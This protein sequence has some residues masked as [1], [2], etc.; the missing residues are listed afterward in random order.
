MNKTFID[1]GEIGW[2]LYLSAHI[3]WLKKNTE[4]NIQVI[5][6]RK[7]FFEDCLITPLPDKFHQLYGN[8]A[9]DCFGRLGKPLAGFLNF[10]KPF[11]FEDYLLT[12]FKNNKRI[13]G[14]QLI[15]EPYKISCATLFQDSIAI[16]PRFRNSP[17]HKIR[18]IPMQFYTM[19]I[20]KL[21]KT[22]SNTVITLGTK[23]S[24][25]W[26]QEGIFKNYKNLVGLTPFEDLIDI[27]SNAKAVIGG[28]S[29]ILHLPLIQGIPTF[30]IGDRI[31]K[32]KSNFVPYARREFFEVGNYQQFDFIECIRQM[33]KFING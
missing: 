25:Y 30:I 18:N 9:P 20:D 8:I 22:F 16:F 3:K 14:K 2:M 19:L 32:I 12:I 11:V 13:F 31:E 5:T 10:F 6:D 27:C 17:G 33:V 1:I 7:D 24:A 21:C 28:T 23:D 26:I 15:F 29:G 4:D